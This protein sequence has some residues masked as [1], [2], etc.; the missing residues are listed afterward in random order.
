MFLILRFWTCA[1]LAITS[2]A[3]FAADEKLTSAFESQMRKHNFK[4]EEVGL[5]VARAESPKPQSIVEI[6]SNQSRV[7]A[8]LSKIVTAVGVLELLGPTWKAQTQ[9]VSNGTISGKTLKGNLVLKGGGDPGFVS[10]SMWFLVNEFLRNGVDTIDGDILVD[11]TRFDSVTIDESRDDKRVDRAYDAPVSAMSF[12]WNS[13]NVYVRPTKNGEKPTVWV[14]PEN[15]LFKVENTATTGGGSLTAHVERVGNTLRVSGKIPT[16]VSE[17]AFYKNVS[18]PVLW[19]G[20]N[21]VQ[22]LK[23]RGVAVKGGVKAGMAP[24][25]AAV[26]AKAESKPLGEMVQDMMKFSNNYVAEMLVKNLAAE[27]KGNGASLSQGVDTI[28]QCFVLWDLPKSCVFLNPSGLSHDNKFSPQDLTLVLNH[29]SRKLAYSGE[30]IASLPIAGMDGTLK[31][32]MKN[33]PAQG[34]V[35]GKTGLLNGAAGLA[36]YHRS[37]S[38]VLYSFVFV[39]NGPDSKTDKARDFFDDLAVAM[40]KHLP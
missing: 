13:V 23:Q 16:S 9:L 30:F 2:A 33:T 1:T 8:S 25:D 15:T 37:K 7:P 21:L 36:G 39:F 11:A 10:E 6:N 22:F 29:A 28:K 17:K 34:E 5:Q 3:T 14:D 20:H 4:K 31:N 35:R 24:K 18:D 12:N 19:S 40:V 38:G 27:K 32:R 26:L